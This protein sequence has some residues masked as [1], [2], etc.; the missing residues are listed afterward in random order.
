MLGRVGMGMVGRAGRKLL[1]A[2][3]GSRFR[4]EA[5]RRVEI[6]TVEYAVLGSA[7][8]MRCSGVED[9]EARGCKMQSLC[10]GVKAA[11]GSLSHLRLG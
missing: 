3:L 7:T 9:S 4:Q 11:T 6:W 10:R 2:V 5:G 1:R 8:T